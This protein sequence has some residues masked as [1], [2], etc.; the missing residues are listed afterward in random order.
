M[1][2]SEGWTKKQK[3]LLILA[4]PESYTAIDLS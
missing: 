1:L 4:H 3:I 2:V